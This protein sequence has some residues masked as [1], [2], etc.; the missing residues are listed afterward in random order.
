MIAHVRALVFGCGYLGRRVVQHWLSDGQRVAA[1]T[2]LAQRAEAWRSEG[3]EPIVADVTDPASL[4]ALPSAETVL[5][6]VGFDRS[7][8]MTMSR[9]YVE[10][11]RAV[12]DALPAEPERFIYISSTGVYGQTDGSWVNEQSP[13]LPD[14]ENGR[15]CLAAEQALAQHPLGRRAVVLRMAGLYGPGRL[16]NQKSL[17]AGEPIAAPQHGYLNL[18]HVDDAARLV[19]AAERKATPPAMYVAADGQPPQRHEY[20][21]ELARLWGAPAP[22]FAPPPP[23]DP[24]AQRAASNRRIDGSR[25][26]RDLDVTLAYPTFR[27]GLAAI[28]GG[29]STRS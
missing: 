28:A 16:P 14:R 4:A 17:L 25:I 8:G 20:Y 11:L 9:V 24:A 15:V 1:I 27:E 6:A 22:R 10:G 19:L 29:A 18:I 7:A 26:L 2:R 23:D 12:L 13:C 5:Y 21:A 3:I